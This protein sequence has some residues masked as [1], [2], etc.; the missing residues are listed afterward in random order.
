MTAAIHS[1]AG[2]DQERDRDKRKGH[3]QP[4]RVAFPAQS[5]REDDAEAELELLP[6]RPSPLCQG[7]E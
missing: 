4:A 1:C 5:T 2:S 3:S 7:R 6:V